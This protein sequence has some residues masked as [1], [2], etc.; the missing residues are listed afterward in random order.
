LRLQAGHRG[1]ERIEDTHN[2]VST[3]DPCDLPANPRMAI[4]EGDIASAVPK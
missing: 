1:I 3:F 4:I 2:I